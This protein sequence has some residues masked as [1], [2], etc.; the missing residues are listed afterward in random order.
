[1]NENRN[2]TYQSLWNA[3][4]LVTRGTFIAIQANL[5]KQEVLNKEANFTPK[6][7]RKSITNEAKYQ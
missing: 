4:K 6:G 3:A 5:N 7:T 1:M 2:L